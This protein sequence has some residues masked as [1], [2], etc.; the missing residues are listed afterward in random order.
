MVSSMQLPSIL[1]L[2][3][4]YLELC[5]RSCQYIP[6]FMKLQVLLFD[7]TMTSIRMSIRLITPIF[8]DNLQLDNSQ[9]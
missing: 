8:I 5:L 7:R 1:C 4:V 2:H 3:D 9:E 6:S